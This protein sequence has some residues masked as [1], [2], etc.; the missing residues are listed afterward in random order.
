MTAFLRLILADLA[1]GDPPSKRGGVAIWDYEADELVRGDKN[2]D[3]D[4]RSRRPCSM[5]NLATSEHGYMALG[6]L[7]ATDWRRHLRI[8]RWLNALC[9]Q[10]SRRGI[11]FHWGALC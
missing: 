9:I 3:E 10:T 2:D 7:E 1:K 8:A 4:L 5:R 6:F 11:S